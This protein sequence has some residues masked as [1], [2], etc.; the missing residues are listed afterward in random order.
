MLLIS[1]DYAMKFSAHLGYLWNDLPLPDAIRKAKSA[2]FDA[3]DCHFPYDEDPQLVRA[4]LVQVGLPMLGIN[5]RIDKKNGDFGLAAVPGRETDARVIIDEAVTYAAAINTPT[6]HVMAGNVKGPAAFDCFEK[7]LRYAV[8]EAAKHDITILIEPLNPRSN[9]DYFLQDMP[10]AVQL[11]E[12]IAAP[13]LKLLFDFF[14]AQIIRGDLLKQVEAFL[15]LIGHMHIA[16]VPNRNEPDASEVNFGWLLPEVYK[17]GY[18]GYIS[19]EY[20]PAGETVEEGLGWLA[21]WK[22]GGNN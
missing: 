3:V 7:N 9:P 6:V 22:E 16:G 2:G 15:P 21:A 13:N 20:A 12:K 1:Y 8:A 17:L 10:T 18:D 11:I 5:T 4:A 19:A 14:H